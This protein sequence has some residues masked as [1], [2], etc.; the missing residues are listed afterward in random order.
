MSVLKSGYAYVPIDPGSPLKRIQFILEDASCDLL[1]YS[2]ETYK[3]AHLIKETLPEVN[4]LSVNDVDLSS[5]CY[6]LNIDT[7]PETE[8]YVLYT[9]GSTGKPKGVIQIQKN[10]LHYIRVYTN[11]NHICTTDN[12]S[13][14]STYSFDA[15]VK[16]IYGAILNGATVSF[17]N[18][19]ERGLDK[20]EDWLEKEKV[21][22]IHMV[23]TIYRH[24]VKGLEESKV[25]DLIRIIDLGGEACFKSDFEY[26]KRHFKK[27]A[28]LINDYGP[29]EAT[30]ITQ[31]FF[32]HNTE[33]SR[34]SL[35]LGKKVVHTEVY[36]LDEN[37]NSMGIYGEGEIVF[38][39]DFLSLGYL[40]RE[41]ITQKV[42]TVD[43][44]T[45]EGRVYRSGD[46]GRLLPN[47]EVEFVKRKDSQI[48]HNGVRIEL[49]E[50]ENQLEAINGIEEAVVLLQEVG[51]AKHITAYI[52]KIEDLNTEEIKHK[53]KE[54]LPLYM[55]PSAYVYLDQFPFT[56]T[57]KIDRK[58]LPLPTVSDFKTVPY[59]APKSETQRQLVDIWC[60]VL[61]LD[62]NDVGVN[63]NFFELGGNSLQ[64]VVIINRI[65]KAFN[66]NLSIENLYSTM[67]V[68]ELTVLVDFTSFQ[69]NLEKETVNED[70]DELMI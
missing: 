53:L 36:I 26:F 37:D 51:K 48:K 9:S 43:P 15:S 11:N 19:G 67:T 63:D 2:K 64:G 54:M 46:I 56:R 44:L 1:L 58:Q 38:K 45:S 68:K 69:Q 14:F 50:I 18:I 33:V 65:N 16:D 29:T 34:N 52:R 17:Y 55:I 47:G 39:S 59:Q 20:L 5:E 40:N 60:E 13:V 22:I 28:F 4:L 21:T 12:L 42:F 8:A 3:T 31:K 27:G 25:F 61:K 35:S 24:F 70:F 32:S 30:I 6:N 23:P 57:G 49:S 10:V 66:A 62:F 7:I 41:A